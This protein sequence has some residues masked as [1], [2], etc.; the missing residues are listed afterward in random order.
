VRKLCSTCRIAQEFTVA[1]EELITRQG[2]D[3]YQFILSDS[4][5]YYI[6]PGCGDCNGTGVSGR[7]GIFELLEVKG[8]VLESASQKTTGQKLYKLACEEGMVPLLI[9][10]IQKAKEGL[11]AIDDVLT[12]AYE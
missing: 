11:I 3:I 2:S 6:A 4:S 5:T 1:Q 7:I 12:F 8:A 10:G 9:D